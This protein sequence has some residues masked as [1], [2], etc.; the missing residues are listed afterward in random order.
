VLSAQSV[1]WVDYVR[2]VVPK[3]LF[4]NFRYR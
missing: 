1:S 4:D 3:G 2:P